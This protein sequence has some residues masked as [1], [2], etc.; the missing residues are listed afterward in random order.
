MKKTI[1]AVFGLLLMTSMGIHAESFN[2]GDLDALTPPNGS[3]SNGNGSSDGDWSSAQRRAFLRSCTKNGTRLVAY[4][5]C[6]LKASMKMYNAREIKNFPNL[7]REEK[8]E[9]SRT[10][11]NTCKHLVKR[12][13]G[14]SGSSGASGSSGSSGAAWTSAQRRA[15]ISSCTANGTRLVSYCGCALRQTERMYDR[16]AIRG[17]PS[18]SSAQKRA[19]QRTMLRTCGHLIKRNGSRTSS[20]AS[21]GRWTSAQ[22]RAFINSCTKNG[23]RLI[24]YCDCALKESQKMMSSTELTRFPQRST[25]SKRAYGRAMVRACGHLIKR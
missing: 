18:L 6:A 21:G 15:F 5:G 14:S 16:Y 20:S 25:E 17:F 7:S 13:K 19:Y 23:T 12:N 4:C 10:M 1:L 3:S 8:A 2:P 24:R 11:Y 22:Q 9:Y